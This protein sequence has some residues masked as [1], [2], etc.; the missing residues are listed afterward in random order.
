MNFEDGIGSEDGWNQLKNYDFDD[1]DF[2][3]KNVVDGTTVVCTN[4]K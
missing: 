4:G 3:V 1:I 2:L